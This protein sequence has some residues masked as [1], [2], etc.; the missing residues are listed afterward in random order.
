MRDE[1]RTITNSYHKKTLF[2][3]M[4]KT[5]STLS[6]FRITFPPLPSHSFNSNKNQPMYINLPAGYCIHPL[7]RTEKY[8]YIYIH[9]RSEDGHFK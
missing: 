8:I 5:T 1:L 2:Y 7:D 3:S 9:T 4:G 6:V